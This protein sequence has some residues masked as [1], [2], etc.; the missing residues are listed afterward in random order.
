M[1]SDTRRLGAWALM[2]L[3]AVWLLG[4]GAVLAQEEGGGG[5]EE[6]EAAAEEGAGEGE[7]TEAAAEEGAGEGEST[8]AAAEEGGEVAADDAG[9]EPGE[10]TIGEAIQE[11]I[12]AA[13]GEGDAVA[14]EAVEEE[15]EEVDIGTLLDLPEEEELDSAPVAADDDDPEGDMSFGDQLPEGVSD[16]PSARGIGGKTK[17]DEPAQAVESESVDTS[18]AEAEAERQRLLQEKEAELAAKQKELER[19]KRI[20]RGL[21]E[22]IQDLKQ[23]ALLLG[24]EL[25]LLSEKLIHPSSTQVTIFLALKE[26]DDDYLLDSVELKVNGRLV[27][28]HLYTLREID[29]LRKGGVQRIYD[30]NL[31]AGS[32]Y[33]E[34]VVNG[35]EDD[36]LNSVSWRYDFSKGANPHFVELGVFQDR[37]TANSW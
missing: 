24:E 21:D 4:G 10:P 36:E 18:Q 1:N 33:L 31:H 34:L 15:E 25:R 26:N 28:S 23:E 9:D 30:G 17:T 29:A 16:R 8:E 20:E 2:A 5:G 11:G 37:I 27:G 13:E 6:V 14:A 7:S 12:E 3:L 35:R 19:R 22:Q 32:H